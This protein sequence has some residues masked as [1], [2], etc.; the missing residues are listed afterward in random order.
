[1]ISLDSSHFCVLPEVRQSTRN[2]VLAGPMFDAAAP[3]DAFF[4]V[5][6]AIRFRFV[7]MEKGPVSLS[8]S[9]ACADGV[10]GFPV[11]L[12]LSRLLH[13]HYHQTYILVRP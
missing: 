9:L 7:I 4:A 13:R 6:V 11:D 10:T 8:C 1:M 5:A 12:L 3:I 2:L